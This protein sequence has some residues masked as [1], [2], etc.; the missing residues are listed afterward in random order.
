MPSP[1]APKLPGCSLKL[2]RASTQYQSAP[3]RE[4][5]SVLWSFFRLLQSAIL[6]AS[7]L[8]VA[9]RKC[10]LSASG[11]LILPYQML[12]A[13]FPMSVHPTRCRSLDCLSSPALSRHCVVHLPH[14]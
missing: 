7:P 2:A 3:P 1:S 11:L 6:R 12:G 10:A 4:E 14:P 8:R 9:P 5:V 13:T